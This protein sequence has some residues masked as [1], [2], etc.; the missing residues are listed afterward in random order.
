MRLQ[1]WDT[2]TINSE[3][4]AANTKTTVNSDKPIMDT[5]TKQKH[6]A[7]A[8][9]TGYKHWATKLFL[10][11]LNKHSQ[12]LKHLINKRFS[13]FN[14]TEGQSEEKELKGKEQRTPS[15]ALRAATWDA[16]SPLVFNEVWGKPGD[17]WTENPRGYLCGLLNVKDGAILTELGSCDF[18]W[19]WPKG[20]F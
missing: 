16:P 7:L 8:T 20:Y 5:K 18:L 6:R 17:H 15:H 13:I 12:S 1:H 2:T 3:K 14:R 19:S 11:W 10:T 9:L 4:S